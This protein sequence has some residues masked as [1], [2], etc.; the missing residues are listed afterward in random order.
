MQEKYNRNKYEKGIQILSRM[1]L[2]SGSFAPIWTWAP[3][4]GATSVKIEHWLL[5]K[6]RNVLTA[7]NVISCHR[8]MI[9]SFAEVPTTS[10]H[11]LLPWTLRP[12]SKWGGPSSKLYIYIYI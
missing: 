3:S 1:E 6:R 5:K 4:S 8:S 12:F 11:Y 2:F 9:S 10:N 7:S